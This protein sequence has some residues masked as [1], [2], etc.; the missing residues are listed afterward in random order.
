MEA[1]RILTFQQFARYAEPNANRVNDERITVR[2]AA[3]HVLP[4]HHRR[5]RRLVCG[6]LKLEAESPHASRHNLR[7]MMVTERDYSLGAAPTGAIDADA[8]ARN[9]AI[10]EA[11]LIARIRDPLHR[12]QLS[13]LVG[14]KLAEHAHLDRRR[15]FAIFR[16][17]PLSPLA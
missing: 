1:H 9:R 3:P 5:I 4:H 6:A 13:W 11:V 2:S 10:G 14:G 12:D 15:I 7:L 17:Q 16:D 8:L